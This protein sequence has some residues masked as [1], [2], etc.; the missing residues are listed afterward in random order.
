[1]SNASQRS[2]VAQSFSTPSGNS[3]ARPPPT[4]AER[5]ADARVAFLN[6]LGAASSEINA[7][8]QSR[9]KTIYANEEAVSKQDV[10][11]QKKT[12]QLA[13][14]NAE[15]EKWITKSKEKLT[16]FDDWGELGD[17][18]EDDLDDLETML[19][20]LEEQ[21]RQDKA[22][23]SKKPGLKSHDSQNI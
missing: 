23:K 9:A 15:T 7:E 6:S 13:K 1:M 20:M 17:G 5:A 3:T 16:D 12:K 4:Q 19:E 8:L 10:E 14:D 21:E 22:N 18:L 11:L 2:S